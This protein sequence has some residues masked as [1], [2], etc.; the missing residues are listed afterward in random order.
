MGSPVDMAG[1]VAVCEHYGVTIIEDCC[2]AIGARYGGKYV[3]TIGDI[4]TFSFYPSHQ[5]TAAG[6]GG[7]VSFKDEKTYKRAKSMRDWGKQSDWDAYGQN[8]TAYG[9]TVDG[10][11]YFKHYAYETIGY[12]MKLP[13]VCAAFGIVQLER[14]KT[15]VEQRADNHGAIVSRL[16]QYIG[17]DDEIFIEHDVPKT[18]IPSW[19]G[20]V[21]TLR[22][23]EY[24]SRD[25]LGDHLEKRGVR[26]RP[27]FAGNITRHPPFTQYRGDKSFPVADKLMTDSLFIGCHQNMAR[28]D[29]TQVVNAVAEWCDI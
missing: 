18:G 21:L 13:E 27:F 12:N 4:G 15:F 19:F 9:V 26:H 17:R 22:D 5:I 8:N 24:G 16:R 1:L 29:I 23:E 25:S 3:G 2:E 11:P 7:M 10:V 6:A 14:L 28:E 20:V